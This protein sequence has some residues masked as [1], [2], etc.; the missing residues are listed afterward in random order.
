MK[1]YVTN[2]KDVYE[3]LRS[4]LSGLSFFRHTEKEYFIKTP[5]NPVIENF[6]DLG[7]LTE[8]NKDKIP[9]P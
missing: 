4:M 2:N 1:V 6:L 7:F 3:N 9:T 8:L 5:K